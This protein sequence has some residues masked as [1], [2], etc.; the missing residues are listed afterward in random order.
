MSVE[1]ARQP[2]VVPQP[3]KKPTPL[4]VDVISQLR[5]VL[6]Y[7]A[8]KRGTTLPE[9]LKKRWRGRAAQQKNSIIRELLEWNEGVP[10]GGT[11]YEL[12]FTLRR[13][14][15]TVLHHKGELREVQEKEKIRTMLVDIIEKQ[16]PQ[17]PVVDSF[18]YNPDPDKV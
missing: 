17:E 6:D 14:R 4:R 12:A 1:I 15:S 18:F 8:E 11:V 10:I 5:D 16:I 13:D 3:D 7:L 9:V 2:F